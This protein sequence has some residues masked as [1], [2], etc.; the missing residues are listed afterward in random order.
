MIASPVLTAYWL[1]LMSRMLTVGEA[2]IAKIQVETGVVSA[3]LV[4]LGEHGYNNDETM[5]KSG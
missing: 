5:K 1:L 3:S 2:I 4:S